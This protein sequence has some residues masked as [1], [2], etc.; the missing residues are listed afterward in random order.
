MLLCAGRRLVVP[1]WSPASWADHCC[2]HVGD[3]GVP[4]GRN[5]LRRAPESQRRAG[6]NDRPA[7]PGAPKNSSWILRSNESQGVTQA[8]PHGL[9]SR[10]IFH[11]RSAER[12]ESLTTVALAT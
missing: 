6:G 7:S 9:E 3:G 8:H 2:R 12:R 11:Q 10:S 1:H 5:L 4:D